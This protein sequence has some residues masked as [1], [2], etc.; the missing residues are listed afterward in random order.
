MRVINY[1]L[2]YVTDETLSCG[3]STCDVVRD[4]LK[5]GAGII[6]LREKGYP[7][8]QK[9]AI[10]KQIRILCTEFDAIFIVNDSIDLAHELDADGVHLGQDDA[11]VSAARAI[12]GQNAII[13]VS[14]SS[15]EEALRAQADG[16]SYVAVS[17]VFRTGSKADVGKET[18]LKGFDSIRKAVSIPVLAIGGI[19]AENCE[20]IARHGGDGIAVISA[21]SMQDNITTAAETLRRTIINGKRHMNKS[22]LN[23]IRQ[24]KPLIHQITNYVT[25]NDCAQIT[26]NTG[27]LP[28]MACSPDES[29]DMAGC[30]QA[31]VLNIGTLS[32]IQIDSMISAGKS[33]NI[34]GIPVILDPVGVGATSFRKES[35]LRILSDV[36]ISVIKGNAAEIAVLAGETSLMKGVESIGQYDQID[37]WSL[38]VSRTYCCITAVTGSTDIITDGHSI[39]RVNNGV[40]LMGSVVGTGCMSAPVIACFCAVSSDLCEATASALSLYGIAGES[41]LSSDP[42]I[43]PSYF[44]NSLI[45]EMLH[46]DESSYDKMRITVD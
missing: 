31:L 24:S 45:D 39:F 16:A 10:G 32:K 30:S 41:V 21:I 7:R 35:V 27:G 25:V 18:G 34:K 4:A 9:C 46:L 36:K 19:T 40:P 29:A 42:R 8:E 14:V 3:R 15:T 1:T 33:A 13:G 5:G 28:V 6:Q 23:S 22:I 20:T 17:P 26:L 37:S 11:P 43:S 44:K 12:L 38:K 2:C